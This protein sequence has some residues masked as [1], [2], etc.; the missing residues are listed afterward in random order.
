MKN[1]FCRISRQAIDALQGARKDECLI[2]RA[3]HAI[4]QNTLPDVMKLKGLDDMYRGRTGD[5]RI[6]YSQSRAAPLVIHRISLRGKVYKRLSQLSN[7]SDEHDEILTAADLQKSYGTDN[8]SNDIVYECP[9]PVVNNPDR[10]TKYLSGEYRYAPL[11]NAEQGRLFASVVAHSKKLNFVQSGPG[12]GKTV[13]AARFASDYQSDH[14][15]S[16]VVLLA[17]DDLIKD[18]QNYKAVRNAQSN[19]GLHVSTMTSWLSA[20]YGNGLP[21]LMARDQEL[22]SLHKAL[23]QSHITRRDLQLVQAFILGEGN[24]KDIAH[25]ENEQRIRELKRKKEAIEIAL[26][27]SNKFPLSR[28]ALCRWIMQ[29]PIPRF[30]VGREN[31][32]LFVD[33]AQDFLMDEIRAIL[34][35]LENWRS[36]HRSTCW[37]MGDLNQRITPSGFYWDDLKSK[38]PDHL[39]MSLSVNYRNSQSILRAAKP[40]AV[41]M[42]ELARKCKA[43]KPPPPPDPSTGYELGE[44]SRFLILRDDNCEAFLRRCTNNHADV[45]AGGYL[46]RTIAGELKVIVRDDHGLPNIPGITYIRFE[47]AKG[48]EFASCLLLD[49]ISPDRLDHYEHLCQVFTAFTRARQRLLLVLRETTRISLEQRGFLDD[50]QETEELEAADWVRSAPGGD[51]AYEDVTDLEQRLTAQALTGHPWRDTYEAIATSKIDVN[52]WESVILKNL[53]A[54]HAQN[55]IPDTLPEEYVREPEVH[56]LLLRAL[57][58]SWHAFQRAMEIPSESTRTR[59]T[60]AILLD[61][62]EQGLPLDADVL[63]QNVPSQNGCQSQRSDSIIVEEIMRLAKKLDKECQ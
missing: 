28:V 4:M 24:D 37:L 19:H 42:G 63:S 20:I 32:F 11:L 29:N 35:I 56:I 61:L 8:F 3:I 18:L 52:Q 59:L 36:H 25:L 21:P 31:C 17:P 47:Q 23:P 1:V 46:C 5:W 30:P 14:P 62:R 9:D 10:W 39:D 41:L 27:R 48:R 58:L 49:V 38:Y 51:A 44:P 7:R 43:R 13:C 15:E 55:P 54:R 60:S 16:Y 50:W 45:D 12:T 26:G 22:S 34:H 33:E 40:L 6:I 57:G 2:R 53:R